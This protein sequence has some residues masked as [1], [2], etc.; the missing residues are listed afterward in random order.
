MDINLIPM[1]NGSSYNRKI[2]I[3]LIWVT[4]K[5]INHHY[6]LHLQSTLVG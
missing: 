4:M 6:G 3:A 2:Q 5:F 1:S